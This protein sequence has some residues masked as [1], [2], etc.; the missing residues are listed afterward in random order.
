MKTLKRITVRRRPDPLGRT[1]ED[2]VERLHAMARDALAGKDQ[3]AVDR[4]IER[5][6]K[7]LG[8]DRKVH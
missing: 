6:V 8:L 5:A 7:V 1:E 4:E 2:P 3:D